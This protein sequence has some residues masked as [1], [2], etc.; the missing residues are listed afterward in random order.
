[1]SNTD[2][3]ITCAE[4]GEHVV[5][6]ELGASCP[7]GKYYWDDVNVRSLDDGAP[8]ATC[9]LSG[10]PDD[11]C[12]DCPAFTAWYLADKAALEKGIKLPGT[13]NDQSAL[14]LIAMSLGSLLAVVGFIG[15]FI[16]TFNMTN[17]APAAFT[18]M[19]ASSVLT[20]GLAWFVSK[21]IVHQ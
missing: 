4:A 3:P 1:M 5:P 17:S 10:G 2:K 19:A 15:T 12:L 7:C 13:S 20:V 11:S 14:R 8:C 21:R 18:A 16:T 6:H 9:P